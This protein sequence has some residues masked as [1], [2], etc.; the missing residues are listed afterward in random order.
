[1]GTTASRTRAASTNARTIRS[2]RGKYYLL[3]ALTVRRLAL[4]RLRRHARSSALSFS[5]HR[6]RELSRSLSP[7]LPLPPSLSL[8]VWARGSA[9]WGVDEVDR[10]PASRVCVRCLLFTQIA[11]IRAFF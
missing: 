9:G 3:L 2:S 7:S 5:R 4:H 11:R 6:S 1:M 10:G 8:S